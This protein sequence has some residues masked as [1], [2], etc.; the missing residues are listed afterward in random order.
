MAVVDTYLPKCV[1]EMNKKLAKMIVI[2]KSSRKTKLLFHK[3]F[4][5][6]NISVS[7]NATEKNT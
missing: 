6:M 2:T 5:C 1:S 4:D 3:Q 7:T